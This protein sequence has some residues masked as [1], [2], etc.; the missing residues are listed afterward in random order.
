MTSGRSRVK[1][2]RP[3]REDFSILGRIVDQDQGRVQHPSTRIGL[4][5]PEVM[6]S[7]VPCCLPADQDRLAAVE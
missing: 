6:I 3:D 2:L 5:E 1:L 4:Q 7:A